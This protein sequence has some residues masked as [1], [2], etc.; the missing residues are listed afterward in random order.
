MRH[1]SRPSFIQ[2][3]LPQGLAGKAPAPVAPGEQGG[4]GKPKPV[5]TM[6]VGEEGGSSPPGIGTTQAVGEKTASH[7]CSC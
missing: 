3:A 7:A 1:P 6:A 2:Y 5:T 4:K